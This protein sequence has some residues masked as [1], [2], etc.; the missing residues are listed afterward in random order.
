MPVILDVSY[1]NT[2]LL[3]QVTEPTVDPLVLTPVWP[4]GFPYNA[5]LEI[6]PEV[7]PF[8]GVASSVNAS[9][10]FYLEESRIRGGYNNTNVDYGVKAYLF[11]DNPEQQHRSNSLI[12]SGILN[13]R[14]GTNNSNQFPI[15]DS[16]T[17]SA[18]PAEGSIQKLYAE[19]TN[20]I[21]LQENQINRA[22][23][24]KNIIYNA[25][26]GG[27][28]TATDAVIGTISAYAGQYGISRNPESFAVYGYQKY[29]TDKDRN[30]VLRLSIDGLTEISS[31]GMTDY[32]RDQLSGLSENSLVSISASALEDSTGYS[33]TLDTINTRIQK[34]MTFSVNNIAQQN[35]VTDVVISGESSVVYM[36][37]TVD[38]SAGDALVFSTQVKGLL[39]GGYDIHNKN[40]VVSIQQKPSWAVATLNDVGFGV[41]SNYNT[42]S[43]DE[44]VKGWTSYFTYKP[45]FIASLKNN[46]YSF[47]DGR[48]YKHYSEESGFNRG[49]FYNEY[50]GSKITF[51]F[52]PQVNLSK[53]FQTINYEGDSGWQVDSFTSDKQG[54]EY[55][56]PWGDWGMVSDQT[57]T[58]DDISVKSYLQGAYDLQGNTYPSNLIPPIYYHGFNRKENK[59]YAIIYNTSA[60]KS[61][62]VIYGQQVSGI[63]GRFATVTMSTDTL[64]DV[65]GTKELWSVGTKFVISS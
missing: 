48:I 25:E 38:I 41:S 50:S 36:K 2:F 28:V 58:Q 40:Y 64:T 26:G 5:T 60:P 30:V 29:F 6:S 1:Y 27:S 16:I 20:L 61:G 9:N 53:N 63:K 44:R 43:F 62:E 8:P 10:S 13:S 31:Y 12:W 57:N 51:L 46:F 37:S 39:V 42:L 7:G 34:G 56:N 15:G 11:E 23:I 21:V 14:T 65:G 49:I 4:K 47:K 17:K 33:I 18:D 22:P 45:S 59:Y 35:I 54:P 52:N 55:S 3:K 19:D 32:F 24:N